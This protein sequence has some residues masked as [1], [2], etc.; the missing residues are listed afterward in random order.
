MLFDEGWRGATRLIACRAVFFAPPPHRSALAPAPRPHTRQLPVLPT[1]LPRP[2]GGAGGAWGHQV[3]L[4]LQ[5]PWARHRLAVGTHLGAP[6]GG[7]GG[8]VFGWAVWLAGG[9]AEAAGN[10]VLLKTMMISIRRRAGCIKKWFAGAQ[11][12]CWACLHLHA[13]SPPSPPPP[14]DTAVPGLSRHC[15]PCSYVILKGTTLTY[16]KSERDV[17]FPPRGRVELAG[18]CVRV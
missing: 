10:E 16:F 4:P 3:I 8:R 1:L 12:A 18:N 15:S 14:S 17:Q 2:A 11:H 9:V 5:I 6:V 13:S 7:R